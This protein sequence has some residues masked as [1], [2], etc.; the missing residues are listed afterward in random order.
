[1]TKIDYLY[2]ANWSLWLDI[3]ILLR[4]VP[5]ALGRRGLVIARAKAVTRRLPPL[6]PLEVSSG[7]PFGPRRAPPTEVD[8]RPSAPPAE[9]LEEILL[10]ALQQPPVV[11]AFSGGRDS[12]AILAKATQ[13]ARA[14]GFEDPIPHTL[15]FPGAPRTSEE[16]WQE[17][18]IRHL[19]LRELE[20]AACR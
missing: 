8:P 12:A 14:N 16:D 4:T 11:V 18:I 13:V 6:D 17:L 3:K 1:M 7:L 15:R 20:S 2:G 19:G 10:Q 5:F 9:T